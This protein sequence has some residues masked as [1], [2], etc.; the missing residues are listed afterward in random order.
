LAEH[1]WLEMTVDSQKRRIAIHRIH[2]EEDAG[3]LLHAV[4]SQALPYSL[5]DLNRCG[6]PLIEIVSEPD[7]R[8]PEEAFAYLTALKTLLQ[9]VEVSDCDMEKGSLRC[10][11]NVSVRPVAEATLGTRSEV[12]NLNSFRAVRDA[13]T[14]EIKRQTQLLQ[15]G[16]R[17]VQETRLWDAKRQVTESLRSKEEAHD[18]RYFPEPDLVPLRL[19]PDV[20]DPIRQALPELPTARRARFVNQYGLSNYDASVLTADKA[21]ADYYE[22]ALRA[23]S[24]GKELSADTAKTVTNWVT[25]ELLGRLNVAGKP[26]TES[27]VSP[28]HIGALVGL[29]QQGTISGKIAKEVF[30][31]CFTTGA[32]PEQI[33]KTRGLVQVSDPQVVSRWI[34]E[35]IQE[36]SKM[37]EEYRGGKEQA[38]GALVGA[39]MKKSQGKANPQLVNRLLKERLGRGQAIS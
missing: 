24:S 7:L 8:S 29:L 25:T 20:I 11:A 32:A 9:Y 34:E 12:K 30:T 1:G 19:S 35:V 38:L 36:Q 23:V 6:V 21:L 37:A 22:A 15:S 4:G 16:G 13:L 31:E 2:L 26:I 28:Q 33:V 17:V 27:P 3:K 10:D 18:Y 39:I 5:V 14:H